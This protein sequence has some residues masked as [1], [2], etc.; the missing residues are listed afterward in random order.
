MAETST[1]MFRESSRE[2]RRKRLPGRLVLCP[3]GERVYARGLATLMVMVMLAAL[4]LRCLAVFGSHG[5][6]VHAGQGQT[7]VSVVSCHH[8]HGPHAGVEGGSARLASGLSSC[9][10]CCFGAAVL[11]SPPALRLL[12]DATARIPVFR[13][14]PYPGFEPDRPERPPRTIR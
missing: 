3:D 11:P 14:E 1:P 13:E 12:A 4:P 7:A 10:D 9:G 2:F 8:D 6:A 5:C